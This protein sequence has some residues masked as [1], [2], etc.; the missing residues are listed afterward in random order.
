MFGKRTPEI[1]G[2][3]A[4]H[5]ER[6]R[7]YQRAILFRQQAGERA[8]QQNA[9]RTVLGHGRAGLDLLTQLPATVDRRQVELGFRQ[10][11]SAALASLRGFTDDEVEDNLRR[12]QQLCRELEDVPTLVAMIISL[13][14][15][16]LYRANRPAL[17]ELVRQEEDLVERLNDSLLLV[18][19]HTQLMASETVRGRHT[20]AEE[21]Y[22]QIRRFYD[23][24]AHRAT[25]AFLAGDPFVG[26]LGVSG[27]SLS[28]SGRLDQGWDRL[29]RGLALA[30]EYAQPVIWANSLLLA[31]PVKFLR[32]E[33]EEA[34][35]LAKKMSALACEHELSLFVHLG[36][37]HQGGMAVQ[38]GALEEGIAA[39][40]G[41]L[42]QYR[43]TGTQFFIPYFRPFLP[44]A[45][46]N[47]GR[48]RRHGRW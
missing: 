32:G 15:L 31:V 46:G 44:R 10:L 38:C 17:E 45:I 24:Q 23:P 18:Q 28:L 47:R 29:S 5:F 21:H 34:W 42:S 16:Q 22:Q 11:V 40:T 7:D 8:L 33:P 1:A 25:P 30:K 37:L 43:A 48:S 12:A 14:R 2:E 9:Y 41:G 26:A 35:Q 39:I 27:L 36:V 3:L 19:L 4:V 13:A 20:R 6:G